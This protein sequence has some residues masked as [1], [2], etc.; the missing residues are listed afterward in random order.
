MASKL[1]ALSFLFVTATIA[2]C[3][4]NQAD[5]SAPAR[6]DSEVVSARLF[7]HIGSDHRCTRG[8]DDLES[9]MDMLTLRKADDGIIRLDVDTHAAVRDAAGK[10]SIERGTFQRASA[11]R[12]DLG[13]EHIELRFAGEGFAMSM[14]RKGSDYIYYEGTFS[15]DGAPP[16]EIIC[17]PSHDGCEYG[18][19][20]WSYTN[21]TFQSGEGCNENDTCTCYESGSI[22]CTNLPCS[23]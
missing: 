5:N 17:K 19:E 1:A 10:A 21:E 14:D 7:C 13:A 8:A 22:L 18:V 2:A 9:C 20:S 4:S 23:R 3:S 12:A 16:A 15:R 6:S 11:E